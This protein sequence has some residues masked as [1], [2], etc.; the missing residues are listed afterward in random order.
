MPARNDNPRPAA[1]AFFGF[2]VV[3]DG[4]GNVLSLSI[5]RFTFTTT[6]HQQENNIFMEACL[7]VSVQSPQVL[8]TQD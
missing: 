1:L 4:E 5:L 8:E 6:L 3:V 7:A 2:A